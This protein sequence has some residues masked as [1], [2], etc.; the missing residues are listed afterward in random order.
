M[1]EH[2]FRSMKVTTAMSRFVVRAVLNACLIR[3]TLLSR[4]VTLLSSAL[5][6]RRA[7]EMR[8]DEI[9]HLPRRGPRC[10]DKEKAVDVDVDS[11]TASV[12]MHQHTPASTSV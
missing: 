12:T 2:S 6:G 8:I 3:Q 7:L 11:V 10:D 1:R 4:I 9:M 5:W